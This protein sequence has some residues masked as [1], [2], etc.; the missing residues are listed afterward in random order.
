MDGHFLKKALGILPRII[1]VLVT[2]LN[3]L[4][5]QPDSVDE[6]AAKAVLAFNFA[7]YTD[8]PKSAIAASPDS[9]RVCVVGDDTLVR[10]FQGISGRRIG[11]R[12][13]QVTALRG[14]DRPS[15]CDLI[16]INSR[17]RSVIAHLFSDI[18]DLPILTIGEI[19]DFADYGGII[20]LYRSDNKIRFEVSL[21]AAERA[22]LT[23]SSRL[24]RL[25]RI[26]K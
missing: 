19:P 16:F 2:I 21:A 6:Y 23:I 17:D 4:A 1:I 20:N 26:A 3:P 15:K 12:S 8:W 11:E 22:N 5:A 24:L 18:R 25:A 14:R 10:S 9:L 7:R 13:I